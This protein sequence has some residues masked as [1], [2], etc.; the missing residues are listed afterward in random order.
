[1]VTA[2]IFPI[3]QRPRPGP[4]RTGPVFLDVEQGLNRT[5]MATDFSKWLPSD[6][7]IP[8]RIHGAGIYANIWGI[9]M[10]SIHVTIYSSIMDPMGNIPWT[11][12]N[13]SIYPPVKIDSST[14][15]INNFEWKPVLQAR[16]LSG[17]MLIYRRVIDRWFPPFDNQKL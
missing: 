4:N 1:M 7:Y 15:K 14:L 12:D 5:D 11:I 3:F 9:L 2:P 16:W 6:V 8:W 10:G 13:Y 17:S